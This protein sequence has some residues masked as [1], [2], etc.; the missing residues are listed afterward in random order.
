MNIHI[1]PSTFQNESRI[2]KIIHT[3][4]KSEV[5]ERVIVIALWK[6]GLPKHEVLHEGIEV[7]R[8]LPLFGKGMTGVI[9]R[10]LRVVGWHIGVLREVRR[11]KIDCLSSHSWHVLP[12]SFL[13]KVWKKCILIYEPHELETETLILLFFMEK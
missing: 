6:Y 1:Y 13:I 7:V 9:G 11:F 3:L 8:I 10:L 12:L 2:I 4:R 5:F